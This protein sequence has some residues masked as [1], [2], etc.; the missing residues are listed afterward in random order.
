MEL[1]LQAEPFVFQCLTEAILQNLEFSMSIPPMIH[2]VALPIRKGFPTPR[3]ENI[4]DGKFELQHAIYAF[5]IIP[6]THASA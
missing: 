6:S 2:R 5:R 1:M 3:P 4:N